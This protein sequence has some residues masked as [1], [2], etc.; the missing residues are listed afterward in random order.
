MLSTARNK[1]SQIAAADI[2]HVTL[3]ASIHMAATFALDRLSGLVFGKDH[4]TSG[5][6]DWSQ[7]WLV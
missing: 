1:D 4:Q 3:L 5:D 6:R 2:S 7:L